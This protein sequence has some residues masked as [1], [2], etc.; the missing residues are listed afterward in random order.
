L[1]IDGWGRKSESAARSR[2]EGMKAMKRLNIKW[3]LPVI[4]A[5]LLSGGALVATG[6]LLPAAGAGGSEPAEAPTEAIRA[7]AD[8]AG[9]GALDE[10]ARQD[11]PTTGA[12]GLTRRPLTRGE[13]AQMLA[14]AFNLEPSGVAP[15]TDV[16]G[17]EAED[18]IAAVMA[19]G[20]MDGWF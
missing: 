19:A 14:E 16:R 9:L 8:P 20:V 1:E 17:H 5:V 13:L 7:D 3:A 6:G 18:A 2:C 15:F 10:P 4:A 12:D 11:L